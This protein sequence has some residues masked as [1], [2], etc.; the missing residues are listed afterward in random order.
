[1]KKEQ[2][3]WQIF[4]GITY[5]EK[6]EHHNIMMMKIKILTHS[7]HFLLYQV[8]NYILLVMLDDPSGCKKFNIQ[9]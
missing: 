4:M 9:L 8:K 1:M 3:V 2:L 5:R 6:L 7:Y